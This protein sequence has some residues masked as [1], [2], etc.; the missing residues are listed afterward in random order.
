M[1]KILLTLAAVV[2]SLAAFAQNYK[3]ETNIP[4]RYVYNDAYSKERCVLDVQYQEGAKDLPVVVFFHGGGMT[5]GEKYIPDPFN[6]C[7]Y[8]IVTPNY[9]LLPK[10]EKIDNCID[11]AAAAV[12][13]VFRNIEKYGGDPKKIIV[14]G[15]SA[16]GYLTNMVVLDKQWLAH[17]AID[18]NDIKAAAPLSG[19]VITHFAVRAQRGMKSTQPLID[20]YAPLFHVRGDAPRYIIISGDPEGELYGRAEETAYF[21]R[22]LKLNGHPDATYYKLD[23]FDHLTMVKPGAELLRDL[24]SHMFPEMF[25]YIDWRAYL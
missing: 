2:V 17:Y 19:Q 14:T 22:M 10:A 8:V 3:L 13:W 24:I 21:W 18:A 23:G 4:Y 16:G 9:R 15:H 1:K 20:E 11:D 25:P 7:G 5:Q 12:A 6:E